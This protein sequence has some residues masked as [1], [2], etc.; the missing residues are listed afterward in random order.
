MKNNSRILRKHKFL[1]K[2]IKKYK[3]PIQKDKLM[4]KLYKDFKF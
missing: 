4:Y 2:K 3:E 1:F